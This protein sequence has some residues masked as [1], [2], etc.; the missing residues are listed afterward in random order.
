MEYKG[1][2]R[3][4]F[5]FAIDSEA[6]DMELLDAIAKCDENSIFIGS[7]FERLLGSDQKKA[8]YDSIRDEKGHV[9]PERAVECLNDFFESIKNG[10]NS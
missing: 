9:P 3:Y 10:K 1:I 2:T 6:I 7:V 4:G 8:F 5:E